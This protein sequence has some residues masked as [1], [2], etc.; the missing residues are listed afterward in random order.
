MSDIPPGFT[1]LQTLS[2][3]KRH[4][5]RLAWLPDGTAVATASYDQTVR[6]WDVATGKERQKFIGHSG[7]VFALAASPD[8]RF[9]LSS[10]KNA[11]KFWPLT[12]EDKP[13]TLRGHEDYIYSVAI[14]PDSQTAVSAAFDQTILVW[15][16]A[17][18][19][20]RHKLTGHRGR[21]NRVRMGRCA[22]GS[23]KR[24]N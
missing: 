13:R 17:T 9:L 16:L 23:F 10:S 1:L 21:V 19:T 3:S 20:P 12:A 22:F 18:D 7:T 15:D 6:L 14:T 5:T 8:G 11:L 24:G 4:L 2:G